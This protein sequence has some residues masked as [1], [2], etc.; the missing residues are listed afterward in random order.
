MKDLANVTGLP[1]GLP[2]DWR[3]RVAQYPFLKQTVNDL[4]NEKASISSQLQHKEDSH[5]VLEQELYDTRAEL[6]HLKDYNLVRLQDALGKWTTTFPGREAYQVKH[7]L[8]KPALTKD[9][10]EAINNYL[11][12]K[13]K[14]DEWE[15]AFPLSQFATAEGARIKYDEA[16]NNQKPVNHDQIT[17]DLTKWTAAF[18]DY[19]FPGKEPQ[20]IRDDYDKLAANQ[21]PSNYE[22]IKSDLE[23]WANVFGDPDYQ[24]KKP[25]EIKNGINQLK[26]DLNQLKTDLL[27]K[28]REDIYRLVNNEINRLKHLGKNSLTNKYGKT[29]DKIAEDGLTLE[30]T[31]ACVQH[32]NAAIA[33]CATEKA[34]DWSRQIDNM[35]TSDGNRATQITEIMEFLPKV[36]TLWNKAPK[37]ADKNNPFYLA[38]IEN[39]ATHLDQ[40][41]DLINKWTTQRR[42]L[43]GEADYVAQVEQPAKE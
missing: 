33:L 1:T 18:P 16:I 40:L 31:F 12:T 3:D 21:K 15:R 13:R 30:N 27:I 42:M 11:S 35:S 8:D 17:I 14:L 25:A 26:T 34:V 23:E 19:K 29:V 9:Q 22:Q 24:G 38:A 20:A 32:L 2:T 36:E 28:H 37:S 5:G 10:E 7:D 41:T 6:Q 43:W 39:K 4:R